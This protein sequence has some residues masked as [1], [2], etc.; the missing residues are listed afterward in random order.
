MSM[1]KFFIFPHLKFKNEFILFVKDYSKRKNTI[2]K[3][4]LSDQDT[5]VQILL[6]VL[7]TSD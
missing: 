1:I 2:V 6:L 4:R 5:K 7:P 3:G